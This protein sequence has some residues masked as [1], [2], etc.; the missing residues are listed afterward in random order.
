MLSV[1]ARV[2]DDVFSTLNTDGDWSMTPLFQVWVR[3]G[4]AV[5]VS[6]PVA[7][8]WPSRARRKAL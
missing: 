8:S 7:I 6:H 3:R 2:V 5:R 1:G 4:R